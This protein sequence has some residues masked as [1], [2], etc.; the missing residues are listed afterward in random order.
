MKADHAFTACAL[1]K[2]ILQK[3]A[4]I[5]VS[6]LVKFGVLNHFALVHGYNTITYLNGVQ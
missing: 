6:F 5:L 1:I 3:T 4:L 2:F